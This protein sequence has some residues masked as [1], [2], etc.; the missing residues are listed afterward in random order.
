MALDLD[1]RHSSISTYGLKAILNKSVRQ[2]LLNKNGYV[3]LANINYFNKSYD[4]QPADP[5]HQ[6][7]GPDM[8][9]IASKFTATPKSP[10]HFL[11]STMPTTINKKNVNLESS[12]QGH[13]ED[14]SPKVFS[15]LASGQRHPSNRKQSMTE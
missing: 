5:I 4:D 14:V 7:I 1:R 2:N 12:F 6:E 11:R 9:K 8:Q 10:S 13:Q 15:P 3:G